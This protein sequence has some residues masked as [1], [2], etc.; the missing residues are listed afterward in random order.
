MLEV[1]KSSSLGLSALPL[2][3]QDAS[4]QDQQDDPQ[5]RPS[6][7]RPCKRAVNR[8]SPIHCWLPAS[9]QGVNLGCPLSSKRGVPA[10]CLGVQW[11]V[12]CRPPIPL[13]LPPMSLLIPVP[14]PVP[15]PFHP[16]AVRGR[17]HAGTGSAAAGRSRHGSGLSALGGIPPAGTRARA[18]VVGVQM[19]TS[20][21]VAPGCRY[22][23][24]CCICHYMQPQP[25]MG[26]VVHGYFPS[27]VYSV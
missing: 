22:G 7:Q 8:L 5:S 1:L 11:C 15:V 12:V 17:V 6:K 16:C 25:S 4:Q 9:R 13:L 2:Q 20:F 26:S 19:G 3:A 21:H 14:S 10:S 24:E 27:L 18:G 23:C